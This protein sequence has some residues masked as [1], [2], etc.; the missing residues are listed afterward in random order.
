MQGKAKTRPGR[1]ERQKVEE[2]VEGGYAE[3]SSAGRKAKKLGRVLEVGEV[4]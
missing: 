4:G 3:Q 2:E 1:A